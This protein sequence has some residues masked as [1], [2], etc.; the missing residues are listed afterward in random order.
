MN[1]PKEEQ[2]MVYNAYIFE[3]LY[4]RYMTHIWTKPRFSFHI[5]RKASHKKLL[6]FQDFNK[7]MLK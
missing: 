3:I 4:Q 7:H 5:K 2:V 1:L 6:F